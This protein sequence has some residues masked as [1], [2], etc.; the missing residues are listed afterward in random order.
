MAT[1]EALR[2]MILGFAKAGIHK[3]QERVETKE[4]EGGFI[5]SQ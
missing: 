4:E 1:A 2:K 3:R 5:Q